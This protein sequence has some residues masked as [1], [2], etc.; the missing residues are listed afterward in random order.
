M[1]N[2]KKQISLNFFYLVVLMA[3]VP[4][5]TNQNSLAPAPHTNNCGKKAGLSPVLTHHFQIVTLPFLLNC[6]KK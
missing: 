6:F 3:F 4:L 1:G 2:R 5:L